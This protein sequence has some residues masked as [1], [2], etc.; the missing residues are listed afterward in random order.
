M[1]K[2]HKMKSLKVFLAIIVLTAV[3]GFYNDPNNT[4]NAVNRA[5][6]GGNAAQ[7]AQHF[8]ATVALS[9]P[10]RKGNFS[11]AQ[12]RSIMQAFF[13]DHPPASF[14]VHSSG[15]TTKGGRFHLGTYVTNK[16]VNFSVYVLLQPDPKKN[17]KEY[18][19]RLTFE[20]K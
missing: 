16:G 12:A 14:T 15:Q 1:V 4:W 18:V 19:S 8:P 17:N 2:Q 11:T 3:M 10:S 13:R 5:I 7:L 20:L 6:S 9:L